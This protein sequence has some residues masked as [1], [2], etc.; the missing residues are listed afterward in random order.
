MNQNNTIYTYDLQNDLYFY[1]LII[2]N[3]ENE[4]IT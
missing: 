4:Q 3:I 1:C 2:C